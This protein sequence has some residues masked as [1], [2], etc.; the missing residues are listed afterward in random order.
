MRLF[1]LKERGDRMVTFCECGSIKEKSICTNRYCPV[2][3]NKRKVWV[4]NGDTLIF[5]NPV[6]Y[7]RAAAAGE[8]IKKLQEQIKDELRG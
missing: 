8:N 7:I 4:I 1:I 5:K 6:T 3:G 2:K